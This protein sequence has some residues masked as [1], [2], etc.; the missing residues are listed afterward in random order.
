ML[1][2]SNNPNYI[3]DETRGTFVSN[4]LE[5][6]GGGGGGGSGGVV[7]NKYQ[8][9]RHNLI[10]NH[11]Q[12]MID[13]NETIMIDDIASVRSIGNQP[14]NTN[15]NTT[16]T[17]NSYTNLNSNRRNKMRPT[18]INDNK[19]KL[20]VEAYN[21]NDNNHEHLKQEDIYTLRFTSTTSPTSF[22]NIH[23]TSIPN[24][25]K[26]FDVINKSSAIKVS[27]KQKSKR[28]KTTTTPPPGFELINHAHIRAATP[29]KYERVDELTKNSSN[30]KSNT[31]KSRTRNNHNQQSKTASFFNFCY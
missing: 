27:T 4:G 31:H 18:T 2:Q 5:I 25:I 17:N 28:K 19:H 15:T 16:N 11:S 14:Y 3:F 12:S 22:I 30:F 26:S 8:L 1:D 9:N 6:N 10:N 24:I 21:P 7:N 13:S 20:E 23:Q 29:I